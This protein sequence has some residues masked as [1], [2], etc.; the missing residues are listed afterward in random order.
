M[1]TVCNN[2]FTQSICTISMVLVLTCPALA[3]PPDNAAV[4][5][6]RASLAYD[7]NDAMMDKVMKFNKGDAEIDEDIRKYIEDN[8]YAIKYYIDA[9]DAPNCDWGMDYSEG[10]ELQMPHFSP[11]RD[12]ARIIRAQA[13]ITAESGDYNRALDLCVSLQKSG[14][15][16]AGSGLL[17]SYLV[18]ISVDA[19]ANQYIV[20]ILGHISDNPEM[21]LKLRGQI[22]DVSG[23]FPS[24]KTCINR[25]L[26]TCLQDIR[27]E[28]AGYIAD[29]LLADQISREKARI[30]RRGDKKFFKV[31]IM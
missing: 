17:I 3:Y 1:K 15:H 9:G 10:L 26:S 4:L 27:K 30:I 29:T 5:Y 16:I 12:L 8:K 20:D 31:N 19:M 2:K 18:G 7:A 23:K 11:L 25:D 14:N 21:L 13:K 24:I 6:Y 28:K 22:Y